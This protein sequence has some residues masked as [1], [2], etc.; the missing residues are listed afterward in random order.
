MQWGNSETLHNPDYLSLK[1]RLHDLIH[2][3]IVSKHFILIVFFINKRL[4]IR[5]KNMFSC[6]LI[7]LLKIMLQ[8]IFIIKNCD[9]ERKI[10]VK[11]L[12]KPAGSFHSL[13]PSQI[14]WLRRMCT[15]EHR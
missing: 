13:I 8:M 14:L 3:F 11:R 2:R 15:D 9:F 5:K 1:Q 7:F 10:E 6:K 12:K 4:I